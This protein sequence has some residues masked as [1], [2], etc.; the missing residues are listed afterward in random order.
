MQFSRA[1]SYFSNLSFTA[2]QDECVNKFPFKNE[3][4]YPPGVRTQNSSDSDSGEIAQ[5]SLTS[6]LLN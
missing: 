6:K 1:E 3:S 4:A 5:V 2:Y